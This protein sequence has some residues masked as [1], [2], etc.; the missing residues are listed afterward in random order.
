MKCNEEKLFD[1]LLKSAAAGCE[2]DLLSEFDE[3][4][5]MLP[6]DGTNG[7]I[8][9]KLASLKHKKNSRIAIWA[10]AAVVIILGVQ[11]FATSMFMRH[12]LNLPAESVT[13]DTTVSTEDSLY[14]ELITETSTN[15]ET[16]ANDEVTTEAPESIIAETDAP[17]EITTENEAKVPVFTETP[18][19]TTRK[20]AVTTVSTDNKKPAPRPVINKG[21][22]NE[23]GIGRSLN[24]SKHIDTAILDSAENVTD[25]GIAKLLLVGTYDEYR[26]IF[27]ANNVGIAEYAP[28][29]FN[30][31]L[32]LV[33]YM[34]P[35]ATNK[36]VI[37]GIYVEDGI[38]TAELGDCVFTEI[39][40]NSVLLNVTE[41]SKNVLSGY[42]INT[43]T[44]KYS[45][46]SPS[47]YRYQE[48]TVSSD[49]SVLE[50]HIDKQY[51]RLYSKD[52][53]KPID[54]GYELSDTEL[55]LYPEDGG[56]ITLTNNGSGFTVSLIEN[57]DCK[58]TSVLSN[59]K[60]FD[61]NPLT[62]YIGKTETGIKAESY[63]NEYVDINEN[64]DFSIKYYRDEKC[65]SEYASL[66]EVT[67]GTQVFYKILSKSKLTVI[68]HLSINSEF[69]DSTSF[70][71]PDEPLKVFICTAGTGDIDG[72]GKITYTDVSF[73]RRYAAG[74]IDDN[75]PRIKDTIFLGDINGDGNID[76]ND[77]D[78]LCTFFDDSVSP[79][80]IKSSERTDFKVS[81]AIKGAEVLRSVTVPYVPGTLSSLSEVEIFTRDYI[82]PLYLAENNIPVN[83]YDIIGDSSFFDDY[84]LC[85]AYTKLMDSKN[86][87]EFIAKSKDNEAE[88]VFDYSASSSH[89][90]YRYDAVFFK[91][92][93]QG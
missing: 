41:V 67:P 91:V 38:L 49:K 45:I 89:T 4:R 23:Y 57:A 75:D 32:L 85:I 69:A 42:S 53:G 77:A 25:C 29:Y 60:T 59:H 34:T 46:S 39:Q 20:S 65:E 8:L 10:A 14:V 79:D 7:K 19:E 31:G 44:T 63:F 73:I 68:S 5:E 1:A 93:K 83:I 71:M 28:E 26:D 51:F 70:I 90:D 13:E 61:N 88:L 56:I 54:G 33:T 64:K 17:T 81:F 30:D 9:G 16:E 12:D 24:P 84:K 15:E 92:P 55:Y 86:K 27:E 11:I 21:D 6:S 2:R 35:K 78:I 22:F 82:L 47:I 74:A 72:D 80:S 48:S 3:A 50:L 36:T 66:S 18:T 43:T 87:V 62:Q 40:N 58:L 37:N 76:E 52:L